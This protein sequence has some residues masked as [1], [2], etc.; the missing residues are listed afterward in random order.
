MVFPE[1]R[2]RDTG[3]IRCGECCEA[4]LMDDDL[5]DS[6]RHCFCRDVLSEKQFPQ[7]G[8]TLV[9]TAGGR[10]VFLQQ[11]NTCSIYDD[12]PEFPC[13]IFG[14]PGWLECPRVAPGGTPRPREE[15]DRI[16]ARNGDRSRWSPEFR[17]YFEDRAAERVDTLMK[18][19]NP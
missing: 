2:Y 10:C 17:R 14:I 18:R 15:H 16:V 5:L 9:L 8:Q 1:A 4:F 6:H 12:R 11:D 13:R 3:C 7:I 19:E